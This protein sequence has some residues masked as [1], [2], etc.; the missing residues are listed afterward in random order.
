MRLLVPLFLLAFILLLVL[1]LDGRGTAAAGSG[2]DADLVI[3]NRGDVFTLDPQRM[4]YLKDFRMAYALYEGL[5]RWNLD[6]YS[7]E[8]AAAALPAISE[9]GLR[10][11]F[12]IVSDAKWSNGDALTADDFVYAFRR[13]LLPD[14]ASY[15]SSLLFVIAGAREFFDW[16]AARTSAFRAGD[17]AGELWRETLARFDETVGVKAIDSRT[18]E[19]TLAQPVPYFLDILC[20]T[21]A[22]PVHPPTVEQWTSLNASTGRIEQRHEW[23]K[24]GRLVSNGPYQLERWRFKRD[25]L[26][27]RNPHYHAPEIVQ[28]DS[29]LA[30]TIDDANTAVLA[31]E[32]GAADWLGDV[33]TEYDADMLAQRSA[34]IEKHREAMNAML[35]R[36]LSLDEALAALPAPQR[37]ERRNVHVTPSFGAA[38]YSFNCRPTLRNG[39]VNPFADSAVR[40]AFVLATDR[41]SIV[42][43]VTRLNEPVQTTL[44]PPGS[45][46]G[47]RSP[48][49]LGYDPQRARE[50]LRLA[51]WSHSPTGALMNERGETFPIVEILW[52]TNT[53]RFGWISLELK[54]QWERVLGVQVE[55]RGVDT[56]FYREDLRNGNF[57]VARGTWYG[58]YGDPTTFL[59]LFHSED[60]NNHRRY[61]SKA[62]DDLLAR[63]AAEREPA[64]RLRLLEECERHVFQKDVPML[65]LHQLVQVSMHEPGELTGLSAHPRMMQYYWRMKRSN[66]RN[67]LA[68]HLFCK[69]ESDSCM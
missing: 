2:A 48:E 5:V 59:N 29:V 20:M 52:T 40:R 15:Y 68:F 61:A 63:A 19:I 56:R 25:I 4:T 27:V 49:G 53:P 31:F 47:Y 26:L 51:G 18:L 32:A 45:I 39:R 62:V 10:Y 42:R 12:T 16:R 37:G 55:L 46:A 66:A 33:T 44:V 13:A 30:I 50:E 9:D 34:Y 41:E 8:P 35:S 6:D 7:V 60:G 22:M 1:W 21:V 54:A 58:D 24:A 17:D 64:A 67:V 23:C 14:S 57:M 65:V 38:F 36:G 28:S 3:I 69:V 11:T 43:N